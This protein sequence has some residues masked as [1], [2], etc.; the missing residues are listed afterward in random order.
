MYQTASRARPCL[1]PLCLPW[2]T[3]GENGRSEKSPGFMNSFHCYFFPV[4]FRLAE[5]MHSLNRVPS[6]GWVLAESSEQ[7]SLIFLQRAHGS[8][9][10]TRWCDI[11]MPFQ[12]KFYKII[13]VAPRAWL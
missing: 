9:E 12:C 8:R 13:K 2:E 5:N 3:G 10:R 11:L 7:L 6:A 1:T 4:P